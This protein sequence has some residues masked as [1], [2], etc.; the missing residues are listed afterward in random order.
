MKSDERRIA[1]KLQLKEVSKETIPPI[2]VPPEIARR[3]IG[4]ARSKIYELCN[5]EGFYPSFRIGRRILINVK[6]LQQWVNEQCEAR[7]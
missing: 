2:A 1:M 7:E 6:L 5:S 3:M 4:V